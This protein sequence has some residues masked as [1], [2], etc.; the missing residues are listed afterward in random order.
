MNKWKIVE[1]VGFTF[2]CTVC[3]CFV[4]TAVSSDH[5]HFWLAFYFLSLC[6]NAHGKLSIHETCCSYSLS[7]TFILKLVIIN[8]CSRKSGFMNFLFVLISELFILS[9]KEYICPNYIY[10]SFV[11]K[12]FCCSRSCSSNFFVNIM[13]PSHFLHFIS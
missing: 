5:V 2:L 6:V 12:I 10:T 13:N 3:A 9:M 11:F 8:I 4:L 1:N 7:I